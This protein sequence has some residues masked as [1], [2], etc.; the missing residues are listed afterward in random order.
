MGYD[1]Q[2]CLANLNSKGLGP[3]CQ[4]LITPFHCDDVTGLDPGYHNTCATAGIYYFPIICLVCHNTNSGQY[5][6]FPSAT[7]FTDC[8]NLHNQDPAWQAGQCYCCCSCLANDTLIAIPNGVKPIYTISKGDDV[9]AASAASNKGGMNMQWSTAKV[10]FS[11]GT[12]SEGIQPAMVYLTLEGE[13]TS[14]LICSMDQP[15][16]LADGKFT[17]AGRLVPGMQ[18]VDKD[19]NP[20]NIALVSIGAYH[21]GVHHISTDAPWLKS[22]DGHLLLAG[23]VV[24]GDFTLQMYFNQLPDD[25]KEPNHNDLPLIGTAEYDDAHSSKLKRSDVMFEFAAKKV[26]LTEIGHKVLPNGIFKTY[27]PSKSIPYGA[28]AL[29][30]DAQ[31]TDIMQYGSQAPIS[32]PIP[33][34]LFNTIKSQLTGFYPDIT[35]YYDTM[36]VTPNVY[37]FEA[38]GQKIVQVSGGLAR[39]KDFNYEGMFMAMAHGVSC[40]YGGEPKTIMNHSAVGQADWFAFG[41]ISRLCWIG[42]SY[43]PYIMTA[44]DQWNALFALV[45]PENA[46]GNPLDPLNDPALSCRTQTIQAAAAGGALPECAGGKPLAKISLE[47]A[48]SNAN[49]EIVVNFSLAVNSA[50]GSNV[51]NYTLKPAAEITGAVLDTSTGFIVHLTAALQPDTQYTLSVKNLVSILG[52]GLDPAHT[53]I[54]FTSNPATTKAK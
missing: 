13:Q 29:F 28:S 50:T 3:A 6:Y 47:K 20:V 54:V 17:T 21:G 23:G 9:L 53:S 35:F 45:T 43:L 33:L 24:L 27:S 42:T 34:T 52:T 31:A 7:F 12:S 11:S 19:G 41:V 1:P 38:Y 22:A 8:G 46:K 32:N 15:F 30:T 4:S 44:M 2:Q 25:M 40:F 14:D 26:P 39:M 36:D 16:L 5:Q 18:L 10:N 37:A 49:A 51:A 48:Q